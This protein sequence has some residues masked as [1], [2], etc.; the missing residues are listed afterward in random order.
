M[1][2]SRFKNGFKNTLPALVFIFAMGCGGGKSSISV[3]PSA[4]TF[5]QHDIT[6]VAIDIFFMIDDSGSMAP[7]QTAM[8]DNLNHFIELF[9]QKGFDFRVAVG[10]TSAYGQTNP[11]FFAPGH[12]RHILGSVAAQAESYDLIDLFGET[13]IGVG[14]SGSGSERALRSVQDILDE[15]AS[16]RNFPRAGAHLAVIYIG[17]ENDQS[18]GTVQSWYDQLEALVNVRAA[19]G[20]STHAIQVT[21][22][23]NCTASSGYY[24]GSS[25]YGTIHSAATAGTRMFEMADLSFGGMSLSICSNFAN[26]LSDL[27][28]GI[29]SLASAFPLSEVLDANGIA[30]LKVYVEGLNGNNPIPKSST[31]GYTYDAGTNSIIFH[32]S[33]IPPQNALIGVNYTCST[34]GCL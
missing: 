29:A 9:N 8:R 15:R 14:V 21:G 27:G 6:D 25:I 17:D 7:G 3:M 32:G 18:G 16:S 22:Q 2:E 20:F 30:T 5:E 10:K 23:P 26:S 31:N 12:G 33:M 28:D 1:K 13:V 24:G 11:D 4:E 34:I 19:S